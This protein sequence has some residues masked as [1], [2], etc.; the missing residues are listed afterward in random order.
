MSSE[1]V[2]WSVVRRSLSWSVS[3]EVISQFNSILLLSCYS[4]HSAGPGRKKTQHF[5]TKN[6]GIKKYIEEMECKGLGPSAFQQKIVIS[7]PRFA[8][9]CQAGKMKRMK[10]LS[11]LWSWQIFKK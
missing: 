4:L 5:L 1:S 9:T 10:V 2:S 6:K 8:S 7:K 11:S 3:L